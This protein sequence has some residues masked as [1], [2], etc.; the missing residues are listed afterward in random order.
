MEA[1]GLTPRQDPAIRSGIAD[2]APAGSRAEL[3]AVFGSIVG[4][5]LVLTIRRGVGGVLNFGQSRLLATIAWEVAVAGLLWSFLKRRGWALTRIAGT[6]SVR[7]VFRGAGLALVGYGG[8]IASSIAWYLAAF[9]TLQHIATTTSVAGHASPLVVAAVCVINPIFEEFL[10]LAY[11]LTALEPFGLRVAMFGSIA[12]RTAMHAY[13]G[14][15]AVVSILPL[16]VIFTA[17]YGRTRRL[18][19][20]VVAHMIVDTIGLMRVI[21]G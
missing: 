11:G 21:H 16:A 18:W 19:P 6:P 9:P 20:V 4:L 17:Y 10:W 2:D 14:M 13:Q 5:S 12:L 15:L 1:G 8:V 3:L 7:D